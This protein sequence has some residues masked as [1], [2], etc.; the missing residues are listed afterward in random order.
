MTVAAVYSNDQEFYS[1]SELLPRWLGALDDAQSEWNSHVMTML[2]ESEAGNVLVGRQPAD[3][4]VVEYQRKITAE[5]V[6]KLHILPAG[7]REKALEYIFHDASGAGKYVLSR[8]T[9]AQ[10]LDQFPEEERKMQRL[11]GFSGLGLL[12]LE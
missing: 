2:T 9:L 3:P 8:T 10:I 4:L 11:I 12:A 5:I 6:G 7:Y 1:E